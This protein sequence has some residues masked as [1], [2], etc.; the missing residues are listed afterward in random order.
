MHTFTSSVHPPYQY[1]STVRRTPSTRYWS[2]STARTRYCQ[3]NHHSADAHFLFW[4][5]SAESAVCSFWSLQLMLDRT[6]SIGVNHPSLR[7]VDTMRAFLLVV[8]LFPV[9]NAFHRTLPFT[10][11]PCPQLFGPGSSV[12]SPHQQPHEVEQHHH[13]LHRTLLQPL[14][15]GRAAAVRANTKSKTDAAKAKT[16]GFYGKKLIM[17]VKQGGSPDPEANTM[18]RDVIKAAKANNVP[19]DVS[20]RSHFV[21]HRTLKSDANVPDIMV[22][23]NSNLSTI[24]TRTHTQSYHTFVRT[25][26]P[27][28]MF[29]AYNHSALAAHPYHF[30]C[31]FHTNNY[32]KRRTLTVPSRRRPRATLATLPSPPLRHTGLVGQV[33]SLTFSVTTTTEPPLT[34][35]AA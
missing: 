15:M 33:S 28:S 11:N 21:L 19:V 6:T 23:K 16:N 34:L 31:T 10:T 29:L 2:I 9:S 12:S 35:R 4:S 1:W 25:A 20:N 7:I 14:F 8:F 3:L 24:Q 18:L 5:R 27:F 26:K 30:N 32:R 13:G 22:D 17:A